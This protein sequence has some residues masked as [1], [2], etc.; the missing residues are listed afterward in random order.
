MEKKKST[1]RRD[2]MEAGLIR[3]DD[4]PSG[5]SRASLID[6]T[7]VHYIVKVAD[8][9]AAAATVSGTETMPRT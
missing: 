1:D 5:K 8:L 9:L 7:G 4:H 2:E 3:A 6:Y